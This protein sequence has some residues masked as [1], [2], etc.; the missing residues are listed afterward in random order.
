V[1]QDLLLN[2]WNSLGVQMVLVDTKGNIVM[3]NDAWKNDDMKHAIKSPHHLDTNVHGEWSLYERMFLN[4]KAQSQEGITSVL[5]GQRSNFSLKYYDKVSQDR[6]TI[7]VT[8]L[9]QIT[10]GFVISR[11]LATDENQADVFSTI[12]SMPAAMA[13]H[14]FVRAS[15]AVMLLIL[16]Q[17]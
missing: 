6:F 8:P 3:V 17:E 1:E 13:N 5:E 12:L 15:E 14:E 4:D 16:K 10:S 11:N 7:V 9:N 2:D